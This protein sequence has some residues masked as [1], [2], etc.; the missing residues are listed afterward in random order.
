VPDYYQTTILADSPDAFY[1]FD[2]TA[3]GG[4]TDSSGHGRNFTAVAT[5][6]AAGNGWETGPYSGW[7]AT[8]NML[9]IPI[10][11][12]TQRD[13]WTF[14]FWLKNTS[15][16]PNVIG[17]ANSGATRGFHF[18]YNRSACA[19]PGA[20]PYYVNLTIPGT[21]GCTTMH[22]DSSFSWHYWCVTIGVGGAWSFYFDGSLVGN[23]SFGASFPTVSSGDLFWINGAPVSSYDP[24][25][26]YSRVAVYPTA[27][28]AGRIAAH[29]SAASGPPPP[30][31][32]Y[33]TRRKATTSP[34]Q[35]VT[36]TLI[37]TIKTA[38]SASWLGSPLAVLIGQ[39][40]DAADICSSLPPPPPTWDPTY[41]IGN[42]A[43]PIAL[44][45]SVVWWQWCECVPG[46]TT[47]TTPTPPALPQ[48]TDE[49][50]VDVITPNPTNPCLDI[51]EVRRLL[52]EILRITQ[53][54][55]QVDRRLG[56]TLLPG[57]SVSGASHAALTGSGS[58]SISAAL[59]V[60]IVVTDRP[61]GGRELE[62]AP[63]YVWDLGWASI[64]DGNGFIQERRITRD[65]EVWMPRLMSDAITFGYFLK[66]GV[67]A[68]IT[69][70]YALP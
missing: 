22:G 37:E 45:K 35:Y 41:L 5:D 4:A 11:N 36:D 17:W 65:V 66:D 55:Y 9:S 29:Y 32:Q 14:E 12:L 69:M 13:N 30:D 50:G 2:N 43:Y 70:L 53:L 27:L 57:G 67:Q 6:P 44:F 47:P 61:A 23:A 7:Y 63:N 54:D 39:A 59:G 34:L 8:H 21:W 3:G 1:L 56:S 26:V 46:A 38:L 18:E 10:W 19:Q 49:P 51:T 40:Q 28:S 68:T 25:R 64:M 33:G 20:P 48:P 60:Q 15:G 62:G 16:Q 24:N 31:C 52:R 42:P 58:W